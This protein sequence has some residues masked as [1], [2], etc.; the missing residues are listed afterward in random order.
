MDLMRTPTISIRSVR[1]TKDAIVI[2][3]APDAFRLRTPPVG[4]VRS[5][6]PESGPL[7]APEWVLEGCWVGALGGCWSGCGVGAEEL[8][9]EVVV[10]SVEDGCEDG[11]GD[12]SGTV[13]RGSMVG[14]VKF[15]NGHVE[16]GPVY[17]ARGVLPRPQ[18]GVLAV[19]RVRN[20]EAIH[21]R[22]RDACEA[23]VLSC[24]FML[25]P[26]TPSANG[27]VAMGLVVLPRS[28]VVAIVRLSARH[29]MVT[30]VPAA[31]S[32]RTMWPLEV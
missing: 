29:Q 9:A 17:H 3:A 19:C 18:E 4:E 8:G 21:A 28:S 22:N 27:A 14:V 25:S 32:L 30:F 15:F 7:S 24:A 1:T 10:G 26:H 31:R 12:G 5:T 2:A 6:A 23:G 11:D 20:D 16:A 13:G